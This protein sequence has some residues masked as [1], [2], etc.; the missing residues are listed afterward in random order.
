MFALV[1]LENFQDIEYPCHLLISNKRKDESLKHHSIMIKSLMRKFH[2]WRCAFL[3][4]NK[5]RKFLLEL[6][7]KT[8]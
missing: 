5:T 2:M 4:Q 6:N 1:F 8:I 7:A 3:F